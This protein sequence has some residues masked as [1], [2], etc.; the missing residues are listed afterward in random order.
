MDVQITM[1][2]RQSPAMKVHE[3]KAQWD[4]LELPSDLVAPGEIMQQ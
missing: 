4:I 1:A 2:A 3:R